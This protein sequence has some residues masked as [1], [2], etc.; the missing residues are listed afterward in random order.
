MYTLLNAK[1][2]WFAIN[3]FVLPIQGERNI[4][5]EI[6]FK[7]SED[8]REILHYA[9]IINNNILLFVL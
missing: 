4:S 6:I 8:M 9:T 3:Y 7:S 2:K 1:W 5:N